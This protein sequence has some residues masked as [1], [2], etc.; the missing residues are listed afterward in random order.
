[1]NHEAA[2][3]LLDKVELKVSQLNQLE[4]EAR[5]Q[6]AAAQVHLDT[7]EV[8]VN[9]WSEHLKFVKDLVK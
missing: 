7:A 5:R 8:R 6:V 1:M 2:I 9:E 3:E 4:L